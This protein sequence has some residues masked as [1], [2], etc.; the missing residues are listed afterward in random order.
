MQEVLQGGSTAVGFQEVLLRLGASMNLSYLDIDNIIEVSK[1]ISRI[2]MERINVWDPRYYPSK[3]EDTRLVLTYFL[4]MVAIDHRTHIDGKP[5]RRVM[6]GEEYIGSDL[7]WRLGRVMLSNNPDFFTPRGLANVDP[8]MVRDWL[9]GDYGPIW[10]YGVRAYLLV[11]IGRKLLRKVSLEGLLV[12]NLG[13]LLSLL[14]RFVAYEDPVNKKSMLLAKFLVARGLIDVERELELPIDNHLT[15]IAYRLGIVRLNEDVADVVRSGED[16]GREMDIRLR[17]TVKD[18]WNAV[19][20]MSS[21]DPVALDD[22]LWNLGRRIC[23]QNNPN[24]E[25]CPLRSVCRAYEKKDFLNE[26][27][28]R[29]THYY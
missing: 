13:N 1:Q 3:G 27:T 17:M 26:H 9:V 2:P 21:A 18:A 14:K 12:N 25:A 28:H 11:D 8:L 5:F 15:R 16:V 6:D 22:F 7:L 29:V 24:C 23:I 19:L 10:D 20:R 4:A